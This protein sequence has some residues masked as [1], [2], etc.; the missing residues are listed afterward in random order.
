[1]SAFELP[2]LT[3]PKEEAGRSAE[4]MLVDAADRA[5]EVVDEAEAAA[6]EII[7]AAATAEGTLPGVAAAKPAPGMRAWTA[8][9]GA[10]P[11]EQP[12]SN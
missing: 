9:R 7:T 2:P 5:Q 12:Q 1:V 3:E 10:T 4:K 8:V 11:P 6:A